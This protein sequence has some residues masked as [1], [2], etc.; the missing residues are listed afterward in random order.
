MPLH[1][2]STLQR[3]LTLIELMIAL[4][5]GLLLLAVVGQVYLVNRAAFTAQEQQGL[6]QEGGRFAL[7][8]LARDARMTGLAGCSSRRPLDLPLPVR[9][10]LNSSG[11][12]FDFLLGVRGYEAAGSGPGDDLALVS[13]NPAASGNAAA[14]TPSLP[15]GTYA[16]ADNAIAGSDVLVL[17][18]MGPG[19]PL[20]APFTSGAQIFVADT[21]DIVRGD[22]LMVSDCQQAQVFQATNVVP[23]SGNIA[24]AA[25]AL[26]PGN[27]ANISERGPAGPFQSGSEV[28]RVRSY[29]YYVGPGAD[30]SPAL[31]RESL[32]T[33]A[34]G[35]AGMVAEEL[36]GGV[37]SMQVLYGVDDNIDFVV[38][39]YVT[40]AAVA[41][42]RSVRAIQVSLL[43]R[44][45]AEFGSNVD[46][47]VHAVAGTLVDP[48]DD[49][50]QRRLFSSTIALRNRLL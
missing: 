22:I 25:A 24:G 1:R 50:R 40:A 28:S 43:V 47:E 10:Y 21:A 27:S 13:A 16:L 48:V 41:D 14:W 8:F 9:S 5:L 38:E 3:G 29:A 31:F 36:I 34:G 18:G 30:G 26:V 12:P 7:E 19:I 20:V 49:R 42:W 32:R 6:L 35:N 17:S 33:G 15:T 11:Y 46:D 37:D 4:V 39:R 23:A 45:Q 2:A 44:S